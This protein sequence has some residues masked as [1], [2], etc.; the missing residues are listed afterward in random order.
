[1]IT[2]G[3]NMRNV[4]YSVAVFSVIILAGCSSF[5]GGNKPE[6]T[7]VQCNNYASSGHEYFTHYKTSF[8][9]QGIIKAE[10]ELFQQAGVI[11][12]LTIPSELKNK[13]APQR[14]FQLAMPDSDTTIPINKRYLDYVAI[15]IPPKMAAQHLGQGSIENPQSA[16]LMIPK[17]TFYKGTCREGIEPFL[18]GSTQ[19]LTGSDLPQLM[20]G[21][22]ELKALTAALYLDENSNDLDTLIAHYGNKLVNKD[23]WGHW[24]DIKIDLHKRGF[25]RRFWNFLSGSTLGRLGT[26]NDTGISFGKTITSPPSTAI[27]TENNYIDT[28]WK[29]NLIN[30]QKDYLAIDKH[31]AEL[32]AMLNMTPVNVARFSDKSE[33][34][35]LKIAE[36]QS[37]I[38]THGTRMRS[39]A[40]LFVTN[41]EI[42]YLT[43]LFQKK[44]NDLY[45][46]YLKVS[47]LYADA[48]NV[49]PGQKINPE[50][51]LNPPPTLVNGA[52]IEAVKKPNMSIPLGK[53]G[54]SVPTGVTA[55]LEPHQQ[56]DDSFLYSINLSAL[57]NLSQGITA[58]R[59]Q[60]TNKI[61]SAQS[62]SKRIRFVNLD[63]PED[64]KSGSYIKPVDVGLTVRA[65]ATITYY[66]PCGKWYKPRICKRKKTISTNLYDTTARGNLRINVENT[67]DDFRLSYNYQLC[68]HIFLCTS[69][70][71]KTPKIIESLKKDPKIARYY[72]QAGV[73]INTVM[74]SKAINNNSYIVLQAKTKVMSGTAAILALNALKEESNL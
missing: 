10:I 8:G 69:D 1:M 22:A 59:Q 25:F 18:I 55:Y 67:G 12:R 26:L 37:N 29:E 42:D 58:M 51:I 16:Y 3:T 43:G 27:I 36:Q 56:A 19:S 71:D 35:L 14:Q 53:F 31:I 54:G 32:K 2:R 65:C 34:I 5:W 44:L 61:Y 48:V 60:L 6:P 64:I 33:W 72:E 7:S 70:S 47:K 24:I 40:S 4:L 13:L 62:C 23:T 38:K 50:L 57:A 20:M 28:E 9:N 46:S 15:Y 21:S 74:L 30:A 39:E 52:K 45:K 73:E 66:V 68:A 49:K 17:E 63:I 11:S 41:I